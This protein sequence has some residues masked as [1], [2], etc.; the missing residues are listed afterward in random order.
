M[1]VIL[2]DSDLL[3]LPSM[4]IALDVL[5]QAFGYLY[6][7]VGDIAITATHSYELATAPDE[8]HRPYPIRR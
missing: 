2:N 3:Q 5:E 4:K 7:R 8:W 1:T 6:C